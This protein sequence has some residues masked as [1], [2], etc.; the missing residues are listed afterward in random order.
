MPVDI[1]T[2]EENGA[3]LTH[4][5]FDTNMVALQD[6]VNAAHLEAV[7]INNDSSITTSARM[8]IADA[9]SNTILGTLPLAATATDMEFIIIKT[10]STSNVV[11]VQTQNSET[12][13]GSTTAT[14]SSQ[15]SKFR[16]FCDGVAF[17]II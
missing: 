17:Y 7:S 10:D 16:V 2:R 12:I 6:A 4:D 1:L 5:E 3:A 9:S 15:W 8:V 11:T 13:N 14:L